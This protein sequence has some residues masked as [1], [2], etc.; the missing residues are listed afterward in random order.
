M[1]FAKVTRRVSWS[2]FSLLLSVTIGCHNKDPGPSLCKPRALLYDSDSVVYTYE[3]GLIKTIGYYVSGRQTTRDEFNYSGK[4]LA[5]VSKLT[6]QLDGTSTLD[7][8]H[9]ISYNSDGKP[10]MMT[11]DSYDGHFVTEFTHKN[12]NL[13]KAETISGYTQTYFVGSTRYEYDANGNIPKTYYT[14]NT[15]GGVTEV[16]ARENLSFDEKEKFYTNAPELKIANEYVYGYLPGRNNCLSATVYYFS[17]AQHFTT[18]LSVTFTSTYNEA[19]LISSL[20]NEGTS[21][22]LNSGEVL[23]NNI[24]YN[25]N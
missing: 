22:Q 3:S 17:Y 16:L 13:T 23:F 19:G 2:F 8:H 9:V 18:P 14:V 11:T 12:G 25:C 21:L 24:S 20:K 6:I 1:D 15:N 10:T 5:T 4:Q 7:S